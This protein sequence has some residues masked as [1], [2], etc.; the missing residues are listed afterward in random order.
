[1]FPEGRLD[2]VASRLL[3]S[4]FL[5]RVGNM[6]PSGA[7]RPCPLGLHAWLFASLP[8]LK[9]S[10]ECYPLLFASIRSM[11]PLHRSEPRTKG[12][13]IECPPDPDRLLP[14]QKRRP[15][16]HTAVF[17]LLH[18]E[19]SVPGYKGVMSASRSLAPSASWATAP[20]QLVRRRRRNSPGRQ[21]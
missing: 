3:D 5:T 14:F 15:N 7:R 8:V 19:D 12:R 20:A 21:P 10:S 13:R 6:V 1:M 4:F 2:C 9:Y 18:I 17:L 11:I 16:I